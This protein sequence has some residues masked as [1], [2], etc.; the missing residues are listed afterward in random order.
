[1]IRTLIIVLRGENVGK[2]LTKTPSWI[3]RMTFNSRLGLRRF[4]PF[5]RTSA[6]HHG[7]VKSGSAGADAVFF[8]PHLRL[9]KQAFDASLVNK[10]SAT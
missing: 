1:M 5:S 8:V 9:R 2:D 7:K 6:G 10:K 4:A 3:S